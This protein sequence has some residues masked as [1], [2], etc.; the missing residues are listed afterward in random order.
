MSRKKGFTLVEILMALAVLGIG[1]VGLLSVFA[2]GANSIRR[3]VEKTEACFVA[4]IYIEDFKRQGLT[5]P[6]ALTTPTLP[7]HYSDVGYTVNPNPVNITA[8]AGVTNLFR[9]DFTI[10]KNGRNVETFTTF[11]AQYAPEEI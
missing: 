6:S 10:Q 2:V 9:V 4:Q 1:L 7:T 3:T 11:L 5:D 8:V